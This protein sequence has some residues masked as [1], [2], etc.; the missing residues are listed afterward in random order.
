M[1]R[2]IT[3]TAALAAIATMALAGNAAAATVKGTV[4]HKSARSHSFVVASKTGRLT[5][6][7]A[8]RS[9]R[10][11]RSVVVRARRLSNGTLSAT[12][13]RSGARR[14]RA[15][16][17]GTVTYVDRRTRSFVVSARGV[18]LVVH[19]HRAAG[20]AVA[21]TEILPPVGSVVTVTSNLADDGDIEAE[22]VQEHGE[23]T[24]GTE[25]EGHILA[26]DTA[27]RTLTLS[28]DDD[29]ELKG[30]QI[31]VSLPDTFDI[32]RYQVGDELELVA[33]LNPDGTYT[34]VGSS[35]NGDGKEADD[36]EH[37]QGDNHDQGGDKSGDG[38]KSGDTQQ[39]GA[40]QPAG[41]SSED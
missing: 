4:V 17:R 36:Q 9:P 18:S 22:D 14:T 28:A 35:K 38:E 19:R 41:T 21:A 1:S 7:H 27:A 33:T 3:F 15:K 11:G 29:D 39:A 8:R 31:V 25:L 34:A 26:I 12:K 24:G 30:A 6:V 10:V 5:A 32:T 16:V 23:D 37:E 20:R 13:V 2:R 40:T